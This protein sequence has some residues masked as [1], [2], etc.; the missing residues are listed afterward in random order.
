MNKKNLIRVNGDYRLNDSN[1]Q[2]Y[3]FENNLTKN[4]SNI[5]MDFEFIKNLKID[6]I[7]YKKKEKSIAKIFLNFDV[8]KD[9]INFDKI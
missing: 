7:N 9:L 8:Q 5:K 6:I 2:K 1:F 4:K 3:N